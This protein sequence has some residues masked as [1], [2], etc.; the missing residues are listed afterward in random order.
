MRRT[1]GLI[2]LSVGLIGCSGSDPVAQV[3]SAQSWTATSILIGERWLNR[4]VPDAYAHKALQNASGELRKIAGKL[5]KSMA[6]STVAKRDSLVHPI[7]QAARRA[8]QMSR[9]V[10][11]RNSP[12]F[13]IQLDS[14]RM[15]G[16]LLESAAPKQ[17]P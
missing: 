3:E 9:E 16:R 15:A 1:A 10:S 14:L 6:D 12:A 7:N 13:A 11:T 5:V 8:S 2:A 17:A 4:S